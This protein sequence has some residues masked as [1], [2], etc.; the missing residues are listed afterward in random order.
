METNSFEPAGDSLAGSIEHRRLEATKELLPG[1]CNAHG[2]CRVNVCEHHVGKM[3]EQ[4]E[5]G[6]LACEGNV[7]VFGILPG[8][9]PV[10]AAGKGRWFREFPFRL[11]QNGAA[12]NSQRLVALLG[13]FLV[14]ALSGFAGVRPEQ[15]TVDGRDRVACTGAVL[16]RVSPPWS[17]VVTAGDPTFTLHMSLPD[18]HP[19]ASTGLRASGAGSVTQDHRTDEYRRTGC[20]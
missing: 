11:G 15:W 5:F 7:Q 19:Q 12:T 13:Q 18:L 3:R 17:R 16:L 4:Q 20:R 14:F 6:Y 2:P 1:H 9:A 8:D 10:L